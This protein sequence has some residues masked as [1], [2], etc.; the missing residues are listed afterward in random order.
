MPCHDRDRIQE[1]HKVRVRFMRTSLRHALGTALSY[2]AFDN[3]CQPCLDAQAVSRLWRFGIHLNIS[4][5]LVPRT[6]KSEKKSSRK[7]NGRYFS[8][9]LYYKGRGGAII[10]GADQSFSQGLRVS[11]V[12]W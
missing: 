3:E 10:R 6:F 8:P 2:E 1:Y 12:L 11:R 7:C 4:G 9:S 5:H